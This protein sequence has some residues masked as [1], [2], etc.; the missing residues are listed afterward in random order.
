LFHAYLFL[1]IRPVSG[2]IS[3]PAQPGLNLTDRS[4]EYRQHW[5]EAISK[6]KHSGM[7]TRI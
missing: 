1:I 6:V 5:A 4:A 7:C 3:L 2:G